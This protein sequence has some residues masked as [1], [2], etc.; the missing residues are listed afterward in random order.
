MRNGKLAVTNALIII[1]NVETARA[2]IA[3]NIFCSAFF[4]YL[5]TLAASN[6]GPKQVTQASRCHGFLLC[7]R[8]G[9]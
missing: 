5:G 4:Y 8:D 2:Y 1:T 7:I 6:G 3:S 9:R